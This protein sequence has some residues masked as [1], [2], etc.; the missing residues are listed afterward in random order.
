MN[1]QL[2]FNHDFVWNELEQAV[3][4]SCLQA[5]LKVI[6]YIKKPEGWIADAWLVQVKEDYFFWEEEIEA[7]LDAQ[8]LGE[9]AILRLDGAA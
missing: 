6:I 1:Q 8:P 3:Q 2:I 4:C 5:G 7:A 9:D